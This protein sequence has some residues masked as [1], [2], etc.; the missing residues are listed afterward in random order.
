[1]LRLVAGLAKD[2]QIFAIVGAA[3]AQRRDVVDVIFFAELNLAICAPTAL[4]TQNIRDIIR[5]VPAAL[6]RSC[7]TSALISCSFGFIFLSPLRTGGF[8]LFRIF[9]APPGRSGERCL[10]CR[11]IGRAISRV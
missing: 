7:F 3:T 9:R 4:H 2:L 5:S 6:H 10:M 11:I 1:M 8:C